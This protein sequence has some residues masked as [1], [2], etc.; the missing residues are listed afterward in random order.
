MVFVRIDGAVNYSLAMLQERQSV[1]FNIEVRQKV[2]MVISTVY[3][4][5]EYDNMHFVK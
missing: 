2:L 3:H 1:N 4:K 5:Q